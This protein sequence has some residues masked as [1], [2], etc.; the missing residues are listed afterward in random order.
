MDKMFSLKCC[1]TTYILCAMVSLAASAQSIPYKPML[2]KGKVWYE[3]Y[4]YPPRGYDMFGKSAITS[5]TIVDGKS[6][7][8]FKYTGSTMEEEDIVWE[9]DGKV[10]GLS[11]N[12][13]DL[14]R[15]D[16]HGLYYD[17]TLDKG[18]TTIVYGGCAVKVTKIDTIVVDGEPYRRF[19]IRS[20]AD[21]PLDELE[22]WVEGIGSSWGFYPCFR[23]VTF[24]G[25][26]VLDSCTVDGRLVFMRNDFVRVPHSSRQWVIQNY[27]IDHCHAQP[28]L[29]AGTQRNLATIGES[30]LLGNTWEKVYDCSE[31]RG[32]SQNPDQRYKYLFLLRSEDGRVLAETESYRNAFPDAA[33]A[34]P[35]N[36]SGEVVLY[37][38]NAQLGD[39]YLGHDTITVVAKGDTVLSDGQ[40][41]R[42]LTLSTGHQLVEGIGCVN[43]GYTPFDYLCHPVTTRLGEMNGFALLENY[44]DA[45]G[46]RVYVKSREQ[47]YD[48]LVAGVQTVTSG[49]V[50]TADDAIYDLQGRRM[51]AGKLPKGIYVRQ[52]RKFV[53]R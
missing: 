33:T 49:N 45:E 46:H 9:A 36:G 1:F 11:N 53:V 24:G 43:T 44:Y 30:E 40:Q 52:G 48:A 19:E 2:Q 42:T 5:D 28:Y 50:R 25:E 16:N 32:D 29:A 20:C 38:Y 7:F 31:P 8:A 17:F 35:E 41:H 51:A 39:S 18:D 23:Y 14:E 37:D 22:Y 12:D 34:Y 26:D 21:T 27:G 13:F 4:I 3:R 47:V 10:Y 6:C 15:F